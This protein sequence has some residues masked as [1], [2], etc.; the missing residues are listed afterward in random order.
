MST[1][2]PIVLQELG[3]LTRLVAIAEHALECRKDGMLRATLLVLRRDI[4][5]IGDQ[6]TL[7]K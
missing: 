7:E 1:P 2:A 3:R 6:T 5:R 4:T